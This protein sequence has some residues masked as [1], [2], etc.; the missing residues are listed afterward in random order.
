MR[1]CFHSN[2]RRV[3]G[4]AAT[5]RDGTR[6]SPYSPGWLD[7]YEQLETRWAWTSTKKR[8]DGGRAESGQP[9]GTMARIQAEALAKR[10]DDLTTSEQA[11][12]LFRCDSPK[13]AISDLRRRW[14]CL[15]CPRLLPTVTPPV[16]ISD[17]VRPSWVKNPGGLRHTS[18]CDPSRTGVL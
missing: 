4:D 13:E 5:P 3:T 10:Y 1:G 18:W 16:L 15:S 11:H 8:V 7:I 6:T 12:V 14:K 9:I 17:A 2:N